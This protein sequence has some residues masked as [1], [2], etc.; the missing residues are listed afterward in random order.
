[1]YP[2]GV[3]EETDQVQKSNYEAT[4]DH[5]RLI[6]ERVAELADNRGVSRVQIALAWLLQKESVTAPIISTTKI[7]HL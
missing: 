4:Q 7:S 5:D 2:D 6:V 3:S 1:M